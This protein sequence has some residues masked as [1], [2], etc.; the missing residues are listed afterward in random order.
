MCGWSGGKGLVGLGGASKAKWRVR[1][2][3]EEG[4]CRSYAPRLTG[5]GAPWGRPRT[6]K[7]VAAAAWTAGCRG[8]GCPGRRSK[9]LAV[10]AT[11]RGEP[12]S[13]SWRA[14]RIVKVA[15]EPGLCRVRGLFW[16]NRLRSV[17]GGCEGGVLGAKVESVAE[18]VTFRLEPS[19]V[20]V[21]EPYLECGQ[22]LSPGRGMRVRGRPG[23]VPPRSRP[24]LSC[25]P[26]VVRG[27]R[28][29]LA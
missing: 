4:P 11:T 19:R 13:T 5:L 25:G 29:P 7:A 2:P 23:R 16:D 17:R 15:G 10:G 14:F 9:I 12:R 18:D 6:R 24:C 8:S 22:E 3:T 21:L 1:S 26:M 20:I 27:G 28:G